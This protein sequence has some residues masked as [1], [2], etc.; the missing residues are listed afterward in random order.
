MVFRTIIRC[1]HDRKLPSV[2]PNTT[3]IK[4]TLVGSKSPKKADYNN[5]YNDFLRKKKK[6]NKKII[7]KDL[8]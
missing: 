1:M 8:N 3:Q 2:V 6:D 4:S 7:N 5:I